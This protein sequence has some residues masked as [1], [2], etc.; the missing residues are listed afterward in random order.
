M[1][2]LFLL[3]LSFLAACRCAEAPPPEA[4]LFTGFRETPAGRALD[5]EAAAAARAACPR[6]TAAALSEAQG[7]LGLVSLRGEGLARVETVAALVDGRLTGEAIVHH[8][9][10]GSIRFAVGCPSCE[11]VL[12]VRHPGGLVGCQGTGFS[13]TRAGDQLR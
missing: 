13:L 7:Q 2:A 3:C 9:I 12:G 10:D 5:A 4:R 8:E 6:L 11:L 1:R